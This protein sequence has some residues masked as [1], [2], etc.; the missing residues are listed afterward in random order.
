MS[1]DLNSCNIDNVN[2]LDDQIIHAC[3]EAIKVNNEDVSESIRTPDAITQ[4]LLNHGII[5]HNLNVENILNHF[6]ESIVKAQ[7]LQVSY[8]KFINVTLPNNLTKPGFPGITHM[9]DETVWKK[10]TFLATG[11][12]SALSV[13]R[14]SKM[15]K[16]RFIKVCYF[17]GVR[18]VPA[19]AFWSSTRLQCNNFSSSKTSSRHVLKMS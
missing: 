5:N 18:I 13:L 8:C 10:G 11:S 14:E 9:D 12:L 16:R 1:V 15:P 6:K 3:E 2:N 17:P 7:D 4:S 19:N